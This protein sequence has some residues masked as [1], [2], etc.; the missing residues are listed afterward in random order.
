MPPIKAWGKSNRMH[1]YDKMGHN[2]YFF[3]K[4]IKK[5]CVIWQSWSASTLVG[6]SQE[7]FDNPN[8][9]DFRPKDEDIYSGRKGFTDDQLL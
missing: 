8:K 5:N 2:G 9:K 4:Q 3:H 6:I 7:D 1:V